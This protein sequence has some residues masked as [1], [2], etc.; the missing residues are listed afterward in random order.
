MSVSQSKEQKKLMGMIDTATNRVSQPKAITGEARPQFAS[1]VTWQD[2]NAPPEAVWDASMFYE[3]IETCPPFFWRLLLPVPIGAAGCKFE[4]GGEVKC[5]Y[6]AGHLLKRVTRIIRPRLYAFEVFEQDLALG[7]G[8]KLLSGD[9]TL[10]QLSNG[11]TRVALTTR[12]ASPWHP[13][14]L[15]GWLETAV[16]HSFHRHILTA[17]R[18]NL[19]LQR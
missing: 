3:E 4:V 1:V 13:R 14:W 11:Q 5:R 19:R 16:C 8:I 18:C 12:Y 9:Y 15:F 10:R 2:F 7:G 6:V 17:M